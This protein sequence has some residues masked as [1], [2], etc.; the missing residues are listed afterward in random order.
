PIVPRTERAEAHLNRVRDPSTLAARRAR[1]RVLAAAER[2]DLCR[3]SVRRG[4]DPRQRANADA[5]LH[6]R[7]SRRPRFATPPRDER[8]RST[9]PG[10]PAPGTG[11]PADHRGAELD[12]RVPEVNR[13]GDGMR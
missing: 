13:P 3:S 8:G 6:G 4:I 1:A 11:W 12:E 5:S 10:P 2:A 7:Y 9:V